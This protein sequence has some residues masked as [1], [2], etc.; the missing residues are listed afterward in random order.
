MKD[1][2]GQKFGKWTALRFDKTTQSGV[3]W[4]CRCDCGRTGSKKIAGIIRG[5]SKSCVSC[6]NSTHRLTGTYVSQIYGNIVQRCS[7]PNMF[8]Y[9]DY[10][11]RGIKICSY[12]RKSPASIIEL[13]GHRPDRLYSLDRIDNELNYS[14][15]SCPECIDNGWPLNIR[16]ATK[17]EQMSNR[18]GNVRV[19]M[20]GVTKTLTGWARDKGI[21]PNTL[22]NHIIRGK[23][24]AT[25]MVAK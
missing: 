17:S 5:D 23:I 13:V 19:T 11:G 7:N 16:W 3:W 1:Y 20:G 21:H 12:I 24:S 10:G 2:T 25:M 6:G 14:C 18:R 4:I 9:R 22:K 15:G 8:Q